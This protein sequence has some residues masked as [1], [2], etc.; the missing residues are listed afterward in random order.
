MSIKSPTDALVRPLHP[1]AARDMATVLC[2]TRCQPFPSNDGQGHYHWVCLIAPP[3]S[4]CTPTLT[5]YRLYSPPRPP[6]ANASTSDRAPSASLL[7]NLHLRLLPYRA[8]G[9]CLHAL[10]SKPL[11]Q[12]HFL[13]SPA[14]MTSLPTC[15][16]TYLGNS[17]GSCTL[18]ANK[19][20]PLRFLRLP[21][22]RV[23]TPVPCPR[24]SPARAR[25]VL[26][27]LRALPH[28]HARERALHRPQL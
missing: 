11:C 17:A 22:L 19:G 4:L 15:T 25:P 9:P 7:A 18:V 20:P 8:P 21:V 26:V 2:E 1:R 27:P 12:L 5:A 3:C 6:G 10:A 23:R 16:R 28:A 13:A 14:K 24:P